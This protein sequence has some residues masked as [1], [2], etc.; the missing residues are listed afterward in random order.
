MQCWIAGSTLPVAVTGLANVTALSVGTQHVCAL[1]S[2]GTVLCW[3]SNAYGQLG[4]GSNTDSAAPVAV[5]GLTGAIAI[6]AGGLHTCADHRDGR[7]CPVLGLRR[8]R[9]ARLG[10]R[11]ERAGRHVSG[12]TSGVTAIA[13]RCQ[14][15]LRGHQRRHPPVLGLR[16]LRPSSGTASPTARPPRR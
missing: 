4:N 9:P 16:L 7:R 11:L 13:T 10:G 8:P 3:G 1:T 12:L 14:P 15:H 6:G 5:M 2:A